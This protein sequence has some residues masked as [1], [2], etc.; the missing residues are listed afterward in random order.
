[1]K[2]EQTGG[3]RGSRYAW[4]TG[5]L[6]GIRILDFTAFQ[7]GAQA[8]GLMAGLGADVIK[9][10]D[11]RQGD[12]TRYAY[13]VGAPENR[14]SILFYCCN[15][16]K[17]S[18]AMDLKRP[19]AIQVIDRLVKNV[20]VVTNNFRP[21]VMERLGL[22]Y[23]RLSS[24]NPRI[25]YVSASGWGRRGPKATHPALD[26]AA[27]ARGG[28]VWQTGDDDGFPVPAGAAVGDHA[29]ALNMVIAV[30][31]GLISRDQTAVGQEVDVS[32]FGSILA[33]QAPEITYQLLGGK[34]TPRAG[35]GMPLL[36][37]L[38]RVFFAADGFIVVLAIDDKRWPGFCRAIHRPDLENDERFRNARQRKRNMKAL[39]A[40][41]DDVFPRRTK[42]EWIAALEAEDQVCSAVQSYA[43]LSEDP[44]AVENGYVVDVDHPRI[45]KGKVVAF[46]FDFHR[47]P[48]RSDQIEPL[49]GEHTQEVLK[50]AGLSDGEIA[51]LVRSGI[52]REDGIG[53]PARRSSRV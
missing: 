40:E 38:A 24:I 18:L 39:Y 6:A 47:T 37:T 13:L 15:R 7:A 3:G 20:D 8:T 49:I 25:V 29:T 5:P 2:A 4:E 14:Q 33:M 17:R 53:Q 50:E 46:P 22:S 1:M 11:P 21:G 12:E 48:A 43:E 52:A 41:L 28:L 23:E 31:A 19:E 36:P 44:I 51:D 45:G 26:A 34:R 16:G 10:E 42:A 30:L 9:V 35:R 27:Q 32:L